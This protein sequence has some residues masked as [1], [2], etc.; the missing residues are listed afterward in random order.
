MPVDR[1]NDEDLFP[2]DDY[3]KP[4]EDC[5]NLDAK[6]EKYCETWKFQEEVCSL[7]RGSLL[8]KIE[9]IKDL[10]MTKCQVYE[11]LTDLDCDSIK[12]Y[13][14]VKSMLSLFEDLYED[15]LRL[16]NGRTQC[17]SLLCDVIRTSNMRDTVI[18]EVKE[19]VY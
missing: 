5:E 8:T 14:E 11:N 19:Y 12:Q 2:E 3:N 6:V 4:C 16:D 1:F 15:V 7:E 10:Y 9:I 18:K 13:A 17:E